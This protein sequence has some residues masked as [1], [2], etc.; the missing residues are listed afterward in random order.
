MTPLEGDKAPGV[1]EV[2]AVLSQQAVVLTRL[3]AKTQSSFQHRCI[4]DALQMLK[5]IDVELVQYG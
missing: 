1:P 4:Y 5:K 3:L 2:R